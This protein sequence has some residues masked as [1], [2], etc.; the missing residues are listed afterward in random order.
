MISSSLSKQEELALQDYFSTLQNRLGS[1]LVDVV[2]F[3]SK[4]RGEHDPG[5][6]IDVVVLI[7]HPDAYDLS[8]V[9]GLGFDIWINFQVL[10]SIR[11][12]SRQTWNKMESIQSLFYRNVVRDGISVLPAAA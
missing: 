11:A 12:M 3:G 2:L 10:L 8:E 4:A 1:R 7:D 6:D 5:S 9:R